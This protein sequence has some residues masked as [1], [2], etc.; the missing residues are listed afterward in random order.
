[1]HGE[2]STVILVKNHHM[3]GEDS[4]LRLNFKTLHI[5]FKIKA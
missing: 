5:N 3:H 1:M 2:I 4:N